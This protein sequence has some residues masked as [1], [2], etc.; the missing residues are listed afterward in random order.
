MVGFRAAGWTLF[1]AAVVSVAIGLLGLR[2][3][4]IV[5][6]TKKA[7]SEDDATL[8]NELKEEKGETAGAG[9]EAVP[10]FEK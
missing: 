7:D 4:G 5:G 9:V 3:I 10:A 6:R 1:A 2:G 8:Q